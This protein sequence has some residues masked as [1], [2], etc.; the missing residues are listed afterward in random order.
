MKRFLSKTLSLVL[1]IAMLGMLTCGC[2]SDFLSNFDLKWSEE[3][4]GKEDE[5]EE[6]EE[7]DE[8]SD[9]DADADETEGEGDSNDSDA[10]ADA[11]ADA[12]TGSNV[13]LT[14][15]TY[16][17]TPYSHD[18]IHPQMAPGSI[19]GQEAVDILNRIELEVIQENLTSYHDVELLFEDPSAYGL[20][21]IEPTWGEVLL[22]D[23]ELAESVEQYDLW[24]DELYQIDYESLSE[25]DRIFYEKLVYDLELDKYISSYTAF[26]YMLPVFNSLTGIQCEILFLLEVFSF[27][28][29]EDA[30]NYIAM[31]TDV[32][33]YFQDICVYE[34]QRAAYG[35]GSPDTAYE[36][37]AESFDALY[38]QVDDCFLYA[39]F[40]ERLNNIDGLDDATRQR[41]IDE[42]N[43]AM[44]DHMFPVFEEC[45]ER[46]RALEGSCVN[47]GGLCNYEGGQQLY[48]AYFATRS[49]SEDSIEDAIVALDSYIEYL[50]NTEMQVVMQA[51]SDPDFIDECMNTDAT[52]GDVIANLD[53]LETVIYEDF[54]A[55]PEHSYDTMNIPEAMQDNFSP[56]AYL[57]YHLD[58]YDSNLIM[59]NEASITTNFGTTCAH[60][61]YPGHMYQSIYTRGATNHPYMFLFTS[62]GY[63]EGWAQ[64]VECFSYRYFD[65]SDDMATVLSC[66]AYLNTVLMARI[67]I[68]MHYE[69]WSVQDAVDYL[70]ATLG[71][72]SEE[73]VQEMFDMFIE[74]PTYAVPYGYGLCS[75]VQVFNNVS[76]QY[77]DLTNVEMFDAY[78]GALTGTY[79]QI[80]ES[81]YRTLG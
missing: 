74:I 42:H 8:D 10:D 65:V 63:A 22:D 67:D 57:G 80:E 66:E 73:A 60:E 40:E 16:P 41:L 49:N 13:S 43:V 77:P 69:G 75:I 70:S 26:N 29:V 18:E 15:L 28:T 30:E 51:S 6:E 36:A 47:E 31:V 11:D 3:Y 34:E 12:N 23:S 56:A 61:G 1:I 14:T 24:L 20:D 53:Y 44:H 50:Y 59:V 54:P 19:S 4:Y 64:Y 72:I 25:D 27:D 5:D 81:I 46:I 45:A 78:L 32:E 35:Y 48:A 38:S 37:V 58:T 21:N 71:A 7:E 2:D 62:T 68:G 55:I 52:M 9:E 79:E 17:T 76:A 39:S 33:R